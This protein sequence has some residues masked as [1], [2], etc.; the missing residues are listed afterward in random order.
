MTSAAAPEVSG[1][2]RDPARPVAERVADLLSQMTL[3]EKIAQLGSV[4]VGAVPDGGVAPSQ[5]EFSDEQPPLEEL[6]RHGLGQLTRVLGT[7]PVE[8]AMGM[9]ALAALQAKVMAASRFGIPAVAH[10]ECLTGLAAWRATIFPAPL[11]WGASFDPEL[12]ERMAAA[13]GAS[14]RAAGIQHGLAPVLDVVRDPRWGRTEETIGEDPYLTSVVGTAYVRGLQS[15]GVHATLKHFAGYSAS[16]GGRNQAPVSMGRREFADVILPPFEMALRDGRARAVMPTYIDIDTVPAT[17]DRM[18]LGELLRGELGFDGLVVSDYYAVSF[19]ELQHRIAADQGGAAA[20][21]LA[22][23]VDVELP[24]VRCY[25]APL[26]AAIATGEVPEETVD[27]AA[28]RVLTQKCE[29]GML[30][31]GWTP[32]PARD[33]TGPLDLDPPAHRE[34]ARKL[35][36]ES[37]VLLANPDNALPLDPDATVAVVGPL[38]DD[39]LAFFGCYSMPRHLGHSYPQAADSVVS[40]S[41]LAALRD[42]LPRVSYA[43]GCDVNSADRSGFAEAVTLGRSAQMV[44]VVVGDTAGLFGRGTSGEGCDVSTL[45]LPGVQED[46][47]HALADTGTPVVAVLITGRPYAIGSV[48]GR[49]AGVVQAF[50]PGEEGGPAIADILTGQAVPSGKLPVQLPGTAAA[51]PATYLHT[52][53]AGSHGNSVVDQDPLYPFGHGLS[54]TTFEYADLA[55]GPAVIATDGT[56]EIACT[57]RNTGDRAGTEVV[58]LYLSDP[59]AQVVRPVRWLAGFARVELAP[60][61]ARRVTFRL[62]ADRL[63]FS[64]L[65]GRRVVEPGEIGVAIGGSSASTP[66][67]G[68]FTVTGPQR[69][70][71]P[72]RVL[73]TPVVVGEGVWGMRPPVK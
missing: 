35:A 58:Q 46:L 72:D 56:T 45:R 44:V 71:G 62:H 4:W 3:A 43:R 2:W 54:Y 20:L 15:T 16:Q 39:P 12:I 61:E 25:G 36:S 14:M 69:F 18:L 50:F 22:A 51:Q 38:A 66:L 29:L 47:L 17:A 24:S 5:Q 59:V 11:S 21:A 32:L 33:G 19:I 7:R 28:E 55:I 6:I 10:E 57:V 30:D 67:C 41:V 13:I 40:T 70:P 64:G 34:M 68:C 8:P 53:L 52:P 65:D 31:P 60:G 42:Q 23:G 1:I 49:L 26:A 48:A 37:V 63:S 73:S 9:R 27:R